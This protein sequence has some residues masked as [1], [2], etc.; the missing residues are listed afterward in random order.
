MRNY[1]NFPAEVAGNLSDGGVGKAKRGFF[2]LL[3]L[4]ALAG[5]YVG[6]GALVS[7]VVG[8]DAAAFLG[9]G[10][11]RFLA[12]TVF[13]LALALV[14]LAGAEL[15]TGNN[16]MVMSVL[17]K[18]ITLREMLRNWVVVYSA[19]FL[20]ALVVVLLVYLAQ[21]GSMNNGLLAEYA[22]K[23][24]QGKMSL[25]FSVAVTRGIMANWLVCLAVW[26]AAAAKDVTGKILG[27]LLPIMGFV[28]AGFEHSIANM[29]FIP[30]GMIVKTGWD[31]GFFLRFLGNNL[32]PVTIGNIIG[33]ALL[34]GGVHWYLYLRRRERN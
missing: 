19:N 21:T 33:G 1:F 13:A 9:Y 20:G 26:V 4:G 11:S 5:A 12:G 24:A 10:V 14:L 27:I 15:F 32:L 22:Y 29:F 30:Y 18:R 16:L 3:I 34:V 25:S 7:M 28:A 17:D 2:D 31:T 8:H 6:I 23:V